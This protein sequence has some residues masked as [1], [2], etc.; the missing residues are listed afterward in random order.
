MYIGRSNW[1]ADSYYNGYMDDIRIYTEVLSDADILALYNRRANFDN[2]GNVSSNEIFLPANEAFAINQAII[3]QTFTDGLSRFQ[4]S[5][6]QVTATADGVRIFRPANLFHP[7]NGNTMWGGMVLLLPE[8]LKT[9]GNNYI[10]RFKIKGQTSVDLHDNR[11][12]FAV[13]WTD[14][15][16]G[17]TGHSI[18]RT[19]L[20]NLTETILPDYIETL[21]KY[22]VNSNRLQNPRWT[23]N[24]TAG[25]NVAEYVNKHPSAL[26]IINGSTLLNNSFFPN[27]TTVTSVTNNVGFT[28]SNNATQTGQFVVF[29]STQ[30]DTYGELKFGFGYNNTG[31]LGTDLF[32]KDVEVFNVTSGELIKIDPNGILMYYDIDEVTGTQNTNAKQ[33]INNNGTLL[34]NGEFSEVD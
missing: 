28:T 19:T 1:V 26:N 3:N 21:W 13:G 10:L 4:Q 30:Y 17:L 22:T 5:N 27:G 16:V 15:G 20:R 18:Q 6:C 29:S 34:I 8:S 2:L 33:E 7:A 32:I 31:V 11:F 12:A 24:V 23:I 25:S 9:I 14:F